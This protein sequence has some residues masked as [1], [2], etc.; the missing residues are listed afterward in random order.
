MFSAPHPNDNV[1]SGMRE[2]PEFA[3]ANTSTVAGNPIY[4]QRGFVHRDRGTLAERAQVCPLCTLQYPCQHVSAR[5]YAEMTRDRWQTYPSQPGADPCVE[6]EHTGFCT[7]FARRNYCR[8]HH[9][10]STK[11]KQLVIPMHRCEVCTL[12]VK[13]RCYVHNPPVGRKLCKDDLELVVGGADVAERFDFGETVAIESAAAGG[14]VYGVVVKANKTGSRMYTVCTSLIQDGRFS[15]KVAHKSMGR[16]HKSQYPHLVD[17]ACV[18]QYL[19]ISAPLTAA[20]RRAQVAEARRRKKEAEQSWGGMFD[21]I[22]VVEPVP[23]V[24]EDFDSDDGV[25]NPL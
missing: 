19:G 24:D 12:P 1:G 7:S 15:E 13:N 11:I 8:L 4:W 22:K 18:Q 9:D 3:R 10:I 16:L 21:S 14:Y 6:F 5:K 17:H 23:D 25:K 2:I 20:E